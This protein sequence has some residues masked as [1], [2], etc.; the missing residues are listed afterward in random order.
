MAWNDAISFI[1]LP[2]LLVVTATLAGCSVAGP[3]QSPLIDATA[4]SPTISDIYSG[5]IAPGTDEPARPDTRALLYGKGGA[6][7]IGAGDELTDRYWSA[8]EPMNQRFQRVPNPDL[9]MVVYPHLAK[10]KYPV[11]GYVTVFPMYDEVHYALP[12]EVEI[13]LAT[14]KSLN[15][16]D[17]AR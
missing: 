3:R 12:G 10:G 14:A 6:R 16:P 7:S 5:R 15:R 11:P 9:V 8:L 17:G 2:A 4:G 1:S 13:E